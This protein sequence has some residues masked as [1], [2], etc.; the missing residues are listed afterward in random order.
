MVINK[1]NYKKAEKKV[2]QI[3]NYINNLR[4]LRCV[5]ESLTTI[6]PV[7]LI[8]TFM[9]V[10]LNF[11]ST[12]YQQFIKTACNGKILSML[13]F[14]YHATYDMLG[15]YMTIGLADSVN[16]RYGKESHRFSVIIVSTVSFFIFSGALSEMVVFNPDLLGP[17]NT[18]SA[19]IC[20]VVS[21]YLYILIC[22]KVVFNSKR[23]VDGITTDFVSLIASLL[24]MFLIF[25]IFACF[26]VVLNH[27]GYSSFYALFNKKIAAAFADF[28][29]T[30]RGL[31]HF[32]LIQ[33]FL[34]LFGIHG[35]DVLSEAKYQLFDSAMNANLQRVSIGKPPT[36]IL[37]GTFIDVFVLLGGCGST[38]SLVL[39]IL[40]FSKNKNDKYLARVSAI[41]MLF[42]INELVILGL[43]IVYNPVYVIPFLLAP[44]V[45]ICVSYLA[46]I[47][48]I[49]PICSTKVAWTTPIIIGGYLA[50]GSISGVV[51]QIVNILIGILIYMPFVK[52][53]D[54]LKMISAHEKV[55]NL[56]NILK[57]SEESREA[58]ELLTLPGEA[59]RMAR[60][61]S[62]E[63]S[64][65][66]EHS[67]LTLYY[68]PQ[69]NEKRKLI[70]AESLL[71]WHHD[72]YG[73]IYPPLV[74]CLAEEM[75]RLTE[76]E[77]KVFKT[78]FENLYELLKYKE[79]DNFHISINVTGITIQTD[80]FEEFLTQLHYDFPGRSSNVLIEITE[81]AT[82]KVDDRFIERL[83]RIKALGYTF[84][85]DDFSMGNTS[86]KYLQSNV[87]NIIKLDGGISRD[88][89]NTRSR[90]IISSIS[91]LTQE[92]DVKTIAEYVETEAQRKALE[93][94]GCNIYQGYLYSPAIPLSK[95]I[96][97]GKAAKEEA[98]VDNDPETVTE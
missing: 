48:G 39:A 25:E 73:L 82:L 4:I 62:Y 89:F 98:T 97:L 26:N 38:W 92:L 6:I 54:K 52:I 56:E 87:F 55:K 51:L 96:E 11:P 19:V 28:S 35:S 58:I 80:E 85:I 47:A 34:W 13:N 66:I 42:N 15:L 95:F 83:Q 33:N 49:V 60:T 79:D 40:L 68:Q 64:Q 23:Y 20:G 41:P 72:Q 5:G 50:T 21:A 88:I 69:F 94:V 93:E 8:S 44:V 1:S 36:V 29:H 2:V 12:A 59:G 30:C 81:Q 27:L 17:K 65:Y 70:G 91:R 7:I 16:R 22:R 71:R 78:V 77:K 61:L 86:I 53:S 9:L 75:G 57:E 84:A 45:N 43:P 90:E 76:L 67:E 24:P 63:L 10:L 31:I 3:Y 14:V 18:P 32:E 37:T 74:F 46:T